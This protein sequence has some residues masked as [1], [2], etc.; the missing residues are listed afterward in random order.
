MLLGL[1]TV[2]SLPEA[3]AGLLTA[4]AGAVL[5]LVFALLWQGLFEV[6]ASLALGG[7][8]VQQALRLSEIPLLEQP[9]RWAVLAL[10]LS[11]A[12][13]VGRRYLT[14][15]LALW[16][17]PLYLTSI[18][19]GGAAMLGAAALQLTQL[20]RA[21]LQGLAATS[22][23]TGL[24]LVAHG[25]DRRERLLGYQGVALIELGYMLQLVFFEVG[26]PQAF[27]LPV[28]LYLLTV[29]YLE[30]RRGGPANA[31]RVLEAA[32]LALLLGTT[33]L[34]AVGF[35]GAGYD[36]YLYATFLLFESVALFGL[37]ALFHWRNSFFAGILALVADVAILLADPLKAMNT[38]YLVALIGFVMIGLVIFVERQRQRI[39]FWLDEWRRRLESWD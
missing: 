37:G 33:L 9:P 24:T 3:R 7:L 1:A 17:H 25:F 39:P 38:W 19:L 27:V 2:L 18:G 29:A 36:R 35:V 4:L 14:G 12:A 10:L 31:K 13:I 15:R 23:V 32:A 34:Q 8:V 11:L 16:G 21:T 30:W 20:E 5:M 22:A 26:Q 28:G 6:W